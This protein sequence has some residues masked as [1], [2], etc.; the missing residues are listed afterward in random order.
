M[1]NNL[2]QG[3]RK[4]EYVNLVD[5]EH[6]I[7]QFRWRRTGTGKFSF[8]DR[9]EDEVI[10]FSPFGPHSVRAITMNDRD[11]H[12]GAQSFSIVRDWGTIAFA[13]PFH[14]RVYENG[15]GITVWLTDDTLPDHSEQRLNVIRLHYLFNVVSY[16]AEYSKNDTKAQSS[17]FIGGG[18]TF[19]RA[20]IS[21]QP[22]NVSVLSRQIEMTGEEVSAFDAHMGLVW[23]EQNEQRYIQLQW[24]T[25]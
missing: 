15:N 20:T 14:Q 11:W 10:T 13:D 7:D 22:L 25:R 21:T 3:L 2:L 23:A 18:V 5:Y 6:I 24:R 9:S 17:V 4:L 1:N 12:V 16:Q 19:E 8:L